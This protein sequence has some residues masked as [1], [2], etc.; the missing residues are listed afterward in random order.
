MQKRR[1]DVGHVI[2]TKLSLCTKLSL[3]QQNPHFTF[4]EK[5][6][7]TCFSEGKERS[8]HEMVRFFILIGQVPKVETDCG[9]A[10]SINRSSLLYAHFARY[11]F[12][13]NRTFLPLLLSNHSSYLLA[14]ALL[15]SIHT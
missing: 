7:S 1:I 14:L 9:Q 6:K 8:R 12:D 2:A 5:R 11:P 10:K 13:R 3:L 15:R 4:L